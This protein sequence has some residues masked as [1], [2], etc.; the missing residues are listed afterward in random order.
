MKLS[1]YDA[2]GILFGLLMTSTGV[3]FLKAAGLIT[4]QTAGLAVLLS[5]VMPFGFGAIFFAISMPFLVLSLMRRG[6]AFT[7]RT[8]FVVT[9]ISVLTPVLSRIVVFQSISPLAAA[10]LAGACSGIGVIALFRHNAS[11]GGLGILALIIEQRTGFKTGWFQLCFDAVV[12]AAAVPVLSPKQIAY[13]FIG[14]IVMNLIIAWNFH[15]S[16]VGDR[17]AGTD[18]N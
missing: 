2:Q 5:Y 3:L 17:A 9:G 1:L 14:A 4:G 11:A 10:I 16:Q 15:I 12:F 18:S 8:L 13:S 7:L 6:L